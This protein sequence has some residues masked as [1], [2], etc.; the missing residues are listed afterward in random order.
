M[1]RYRRWTIITALRDRKAH[2]AAQ[3]WLGRNWWMKY[4]RMW[5][6]EEIARSLL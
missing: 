1:I 6:L 5:L 2:A 4:T 3:I